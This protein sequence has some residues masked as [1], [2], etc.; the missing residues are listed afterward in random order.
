MRNVI[1]K[2][3]YNYILD[4]LSD[5][6][7]PIIESNNSWQSPQSDGDVGFCKGYRLTQ[8]YNTGE[9]CYKT[10]PRK[11]RERIQRHTK[12]ISEQ[13]FVDFD[14][15]FL[16]DQFESH[17]FTFTPS[18]Y[19]YILKFG[20]TLLSRVEKNNKYQ[21]K[22]VLNLIGRWLYEVE[23]IQESEP[24]RSVSLK[25]LRT[26]S[27]LTNL[28]SKLRPFLLCDG[29][30]LWMIDVIASQPYILSTVLSDRFINGTG[31]GYNLRTIYPEIIDELIDNGILMSLDTTFQENGFEYGSTITGKTSSYYVSNDT[32]G[33]GKETH[34]LSFPFMWSLFSDKVDKESI[35]KYRRAPFK[36]DFYKDLILKSNNVSE[37]IDEQREVLKNN[38]MYIL[39]DDNKYHRNNAWSM[40]MFYEEYPGV[41]KWITRMHDSV[42]KSKLSYLLQRAESYLVLNGVARQF[43]EKFPSAPIFTIHDAIYTYPEYLPDLHRMIQEDFYSI[44]GIDVGVKIKP[45]KPNPEPKLKD[46]DEV[47]G[48]IRPVRNQDKFEEVRN[49]V[50]SINIDRGAE[51]LKRSMSLS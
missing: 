5:P 22:M 12:D 21:R 34:S 47:W 33:N 9:I 7:D 46:V 45:E 41:N 50:F 14:Y 20:N 44:T 3:D 17:K 18:V 16:L 43:H 37:N 13:C 1:G 8:K 30:L 51:F 10:L 23:R 28:N 24:W 11:F 32:G 31:E 26:H 27:S 38:M 35:D 19:N 36:E 48:E 4:L 40:L 6:T 39:F 29:Q 42:G 2:E 49:G 15:Q 25:N